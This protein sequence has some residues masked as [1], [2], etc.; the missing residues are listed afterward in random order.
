MPTYRSRVAAALFILLAAGS[1]TAAPGWT[2]HLIE[3]SGTCSFA[4]NASNHV[5]YVRTSGATRQV[6]LYD[7]V[8]STLVYAPASAADPQP[9][10]NNAIARPATGALTVGL[11]DDGL[12]SFEADTPAG[13][14]IALA[15]AGQG[16]I[17]PF[18]STP[19][20]PAGGSVS[21]G[22]NALG[23]FGIRLNTGNRLGVTNGVAAEAE[24]IPGFSGSLV[25]TA[26]AIDSESRVAFLY[27]GVSSANSLAVFDPNLSGAGRMRTI[28]LDA[29][30]PINT[31]RPAQPSMASRG[32]ASWVSFVSA[33]F[34]GLPDHSAVYAISTVAPTPSLL[35]IAD[36]VSGYFSSFFNWTSANDQGL[37]AFSALLSA[38]GSGL[39]VG[40]LAQVTPIPVLLS[41]D[42]ITTAAGLAIAGFNVNLGTSSNGLSPSGAVVVQ[43]QTLQVGTTSHQVGLLLA[44]PPA[45]ATPGWPVQPLPAPLP[46]G[47]SAFHLQPCAQTGVLAQT[48]TCFI[49]PAIAAGYDYA[50]SAGA[51]AVT[52]VLIPAPL[53]GGDEDFTLE[54]NG[55]SFPLAAGTTFD[56]TTVDPAGVSAFRISGIELLEALDPADPNA[57]VTGLT[58]AAP[59]GPA[60]ELTMI[61]IV[62]NSEDLDLD[63]IEAANDNCPSVANASQA[64][65]DGDGLGDACDNCAALAN[66]SQADGDGDSVGDACDNCSAGFNPVQLDDDADAVGD[67]CDNCAYTPN[68]GQSDVGGIGPAAPPDGIGDVCQCGDVNGNG[69]VTTA[70]ATLVTRSLLVP[71][72][73]TLAQ[74]ALC[75]V[76]G[77]TACSTADATILTRAL[78]V[79]PTA[80]ISQACAPAIP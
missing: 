71:P 54:V 50:V 63:G 33:D 24:V 27:R 46:A 57:F 2:Y 67:V 18:P 36:Q 79:P 19:N 48:I 49:D 4:I 37:V 53:P 51:P 9:V 62:V 12:I 55:Q 31:L 45:G 29:L 59:P 41:T 30:G 13:R 34:N 69:R 58:F 64:D 47:G 7:G 72:T 10:C 21:A 32:K 28:N 39:F 60:D 16:L 44:V 11:R 76:G 65:G 52:S 6:M 78:L 23:N 80:T 26:P 22:A 15:R 68:V 40:H 73:A 74:P 1:A 61:P 70:D 8:A 38:G 3:P 20:S 77:T 14:V 75:D 35:T 66:A 42:A 56:L 43:A 25:A 5:A 17:G